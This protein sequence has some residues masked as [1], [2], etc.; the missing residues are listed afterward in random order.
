[1]FLLGD[2]VVEIEYRF[3]PQR[4]AGNGIDIINTDKIELLQAFKQSGG[5]TGMNT[6]GNIEAAASQLI[7]MSAGGVHQVGSSRLNRSP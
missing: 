1:M 3:F 6:Q 4:V 5:D 7:G 2:S